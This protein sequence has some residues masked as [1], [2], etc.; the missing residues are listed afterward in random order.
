MKKIYLL[1][2][3]V[4]FSFSGCETAKSIMDS[5]NTSGGGLSNADVVQGL[6]EALKVGMDSATYHLG[7]LNGFFKDNA[8]KILMPP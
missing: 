3:I 5:V 6:K 8:I 4:L 7:M 1:A 2:L